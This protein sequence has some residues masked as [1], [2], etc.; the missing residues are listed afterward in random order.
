MSPCVV[1]SFKAGSFALLVDAFTAAEVPSPLSSVV[2]LA[3]A[4]PAL[5]IYLL[6]HTGAQWPTFL[7]WF[8]TSLL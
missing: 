3:K 4:W 6:K 7:Q 5:P 2:A 1:L 8:Q